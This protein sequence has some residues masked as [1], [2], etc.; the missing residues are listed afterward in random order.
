[1]NRSW[2][3]ALGVLAAAWPAWAQRAD[4]FA[5][6]EVLFKSAMAADLDLD[7]RLATLADLAK[8]H[9]RSRWADDAV[10]AMGELCAQHKRRDEAIEHKIRL[11]K[12]YPRC[13]LQPYT[14]TTTVYRKSFVPV[15]EKLF[16]STGH[17]RV[18]KNRRVAFVSAAPTAVNHDLAGMYE[19]RGDYKQAKRYYEACLRRLPKEGVLARFIRK[20]HGRVC[21]MLELQEQLKQYRPKGDA[22]GR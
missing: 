20:S 15:L 6:P 19:R 2:L 22:G 4:E 16:H 1:M 12:R 21:K 17:A 11:V 10:W 13:V 9:P 8:R 3:A 7:H 5:D 18:G 14:K